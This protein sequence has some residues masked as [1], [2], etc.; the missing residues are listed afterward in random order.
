MLSANTFTFN[1]IRFTN[2]HMMCTVCLKR[3]WDVVKKYVTRWI[4]G[5]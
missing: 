2:I 5:G 4:R 3:L 1:F